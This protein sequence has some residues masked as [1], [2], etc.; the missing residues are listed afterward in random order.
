MIYEKCFT[1]TAKDKIRKRTAFYGKSSRDKAVYVINA[2]NILVAQI[3]QVNFRD[4]FL[5]TFTYAH[6]VL[7]KVNVLRTK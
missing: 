7:L 5:Y 3:Y 4:F 2:E 1:W 6:S